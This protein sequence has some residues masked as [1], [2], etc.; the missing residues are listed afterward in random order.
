MNPLRIGTRRSA[1][2]TAQAREVAALLAARG[3]DTEL[4]LITTGGD[5]GEGPNADAAGGLKGLFVAEI[6]RALL[7]GGVDL[8][9]HSAKDLPVE[10]TEGLVLAAVPLR[11][12]PFDVLVWG[13]A[14]IAPEPVVGTSSLRRVAQLANAFPDYRLETLRG[15]VDTRLAKVRNG[16]IDGAVLAEAGLQRLGIRPRFV[17]R[18]AP[19]VMLPAPGQGALAIQARADDAAT[20]EALAP[21]DD[22]P[23]RTA[24]DAEFALVRRLGGGCSL[25]LGGFAEVDGEDIRLTGLVATP[26]GERV[27]RAEARGESPEGVA[28]YVADELIARGAADILDAARG[29]G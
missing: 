11:A 19:D 17:T 24:V 20:L 26:D 28:R 8:A 2:A 16:E 29:E 4:A 9:V 1:L 15:N 13:E 10:E 23:S 25:P 7:S 3:V 22:G 14:R 12:S 21:L 18:L 27:L 6:V 5:R